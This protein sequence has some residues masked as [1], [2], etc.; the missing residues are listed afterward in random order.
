MP[1]LALSSVKHSRTISDT[2][3][4]RLSN[5]K[6]EMPRRPTSTSTP[7]DFTSWRHHVSQ[8]PHVKMTFTFYALLPGVCTTSP[9][10]RECGATTCV[11]HATGAI[12]ADAQDGV[13]FRR[14]VQ[15]AAILTAAV[16]SLSHL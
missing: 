16:E 10:S 8:V 12:Q 6:T 5:Y 4:L 13:E 1:I 15:Y 9:S 3:G 2:S 7:A 11:R 14:R